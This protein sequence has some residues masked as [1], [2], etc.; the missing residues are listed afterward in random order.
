MNIKE[1]IQTMRVGDERKSLQWYN[2]Q[3]NRL[4]LRSVE[5]EQIIASNV[6]PATSKVV[7]GNMYM[8][9][10]V[11][12]H[13]ETLPYFDLFPLVL[14]FSFVPDGFIGLNM[15]YLSPKMRQILFH[16]L[17]KIT[18]QKHIT[19]TSKMR[20][21]WNLLNTASNMPEI[22]PCIKRYAMTHLRT[23]L[24]RINPLDWA[25]IIMLPLESFIGETKERV[26]RNSAL[27][28]Q[29]YA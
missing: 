15:H 29:K 3:I 13:V 17:L 16:K 9:A 6:A 10:Y 7:W 5:P 4:G 28:T 2:S 25:S 1:K 11:P 21:R 22:R 24:L 26:Y 19:E 27:T 20:A 18:E 14:P 12:I 23:R 8:F